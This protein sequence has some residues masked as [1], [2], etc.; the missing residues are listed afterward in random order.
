MKRLKYTLFTILLLIAALQ[1]AGQS[2]VDK[3]CL[4]AERHYRIK[5]EVGST[6]V[7]QLTD[8]AGKIVGTPTG[9]KFTEGSQEGSE[10]V[11]KWTQTGIFKIVVLQTS[12]FGC[13]AQELGMVEVVVQPKA[14]AGKN[15]SICNG[16]PITLTEATAS[17][18]STLMW[19]TSGDG[20]F[21]DP[22]I[23]HPVY[24]PGPNDNFN[25]TVTLTLTAEG[26]GNSGS[27][28]PAVSSITVVS[29]FQITPL[30]NTIP[31]L[32][33]NSTP[34]LLEGISSN[35][36]KGTWTPAK[37]NTATAGSTSYTFTPDP[38]QC[39]NVKVKINVIVNKYVTP[40][41]DNI[42]PLCQYSTTPAAL[43]TSSKDV[44]AITGAWTPAFSTAKAGNTNYTFVPDK[45]DQC[46]L[47][48]TS[49]VTVNPFI[50]T[51][52]DPIGVVCQNSTAPVLPKISTN[53]TAVRGTW[54]PDKIDTKDLGTFEYI[55]TP[56]D[57]QCA[58]GVK[59]KVTVK[60]VIDPSFNKIGPLCLNN[61]APPLPL[62]STNKSPVTGTWTP[63]VVNTTTVGTTRYDFKPD[64]GQCALPTSLSVAV[65]SSAVIP[66]FAQIE[67]IC[68]GSVVNPLPTTSPNGIT[69]IWSP[70]FSNKAT[71]TYEFTPAAGQCASPVKMTV[72]I[73]AN[74][75]ITPKFTAIPPICKGTLV[76]PLPNTSVEGI[77][78]VWS[79]GFNNKVNTTYTFTPETG[80]CALPAQL[81]VT[82][83]PGS[84]IPIFAEIA[85]CK[86]APG[87][88]LPSTSLDGITGTWSPA[89]DNTVTSKYTFTPDEGQCAKAT[90]LTVTVKPIITPTF[91]QMDTLCQHSIGIRA[92]PA[93]STNTTPITG[94]WLPA[95][96]TAIAGKTTYTFTPGAGQCADKGAIDV[97]VIPQIAPLF[98]K[99]DTLCQYSTTLK[100]LPTSSINTIPITGKWFPAFSTAK[101]GKTSYTF[102]PDAGQC[103]T[104]AKVDVVV[105][106]P[107]ITTFTQI[108]PLCQNSVAIKALP[109]SSANK[110]PI[111]GIW[112]PKFSTETAGTTIYNFKPDSG[113]CATNAKMIV[114][115]N[116]R[117]KPAFIQEGAMC[118]HSTLPTPLRTSSF[119]ATP[120]TGRWSPA[121]STATAGIN[122]YTFTPDSGQC[123]TTAKMGLEIIPQIIPT[124]TQ[125]ATTCLNSS[126]LA[127]PPSVSTNSTPITGKWS[128]AFDPA[129][130]GTTRYTFKPND[131][132]CAAD[133]IM[134]ITI[135]P[136]IIPTFAAIHPL[137][138]NSTP[139]ALAST[140]INGITGTWNPATIN[141]SIVGTTK[142]EFIPDADQC[143]A[144]AS[145][146]IT[147]RLGAIIA[148]ATE[149]GSCVNVLLDGSSSIGDISKYEWSVLD[150]GGQLT[151]TLGITTEFLLSPS[152]AGPLPADFRVRLEV[153]DDQGDTSSDTVSIKVD[154]RPVANIYSSGEL[155]KDGGM[156]VDGSVST[157]KALTYKWSTTVGTILSVDDEAT[158]LLN[159]AG[160]Y[161][162]EV[163][164][165]YG[166]K[167]RKNFVF[168]FDL[169]QI[170]ARPD[171]TRTSWAN[172]TII[173]VLANDLSTVKLLTGSVQVV[174]QPARGKTKV[175]A[176]G[177]ITYTPVDRRPGRDEF[178]YE[179]CDALSFC[180]QATV[181]I[182]I[183]DSGIIATE[184]FS[185][186]GDGINDM[187]VFEGLERYPKSSLYIYTRS[188][189]LVYESNNYLNDWD[190][191]TINSTAN[192]QKLVP[193]GTYYY[194]LKLGGTNR[195]MKGFIYVGY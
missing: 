186:N 176:D 32:C 192:S 45:K 67:P 41:F 44:P 9:S 170:I 38:K 16:T 142:Y 181:T 1:V 121:F 104:V 82:V 96:S 95:F 165:S 29:D 77:T 11:V 5:G 110:M 153:S 166:C 155:E 98:A 123:A 140:S 158:A 148:G 164:D 59:I 30:F 150:T 109:S 190:G 154:S 116:G 184:G 40:S 17:D 91:A 139:P 50:T 58:S 63:S 28:T 118:Q 193:S 191:R 99:I 21:N 55:F 136:L 132:Q 27:C 106:S 76:N 103:A 66:D 34:P 57:G 175:N 86:G 126:T 130:V 152:Y 46:Y 52:F 81:L 156:V 15:F 195:S 31:L 75:N 125:I 72:K 23:L 93:S 117:T 172:D 88:P 119:N 168:P 183:Y 53:S 71:G 182:D 100:A 180:A 177:S 141:T 189:Q 94:T 24:T 169:H 10:V 124:F 22:K 188:G 6:Y 173:K 83:D 19:S 107:T 61:T 146:D 36:I 65:N 187:L 178:I 128:P 159:G 194:V 54:S 179:V 12:S 89:F 37:I 145:L 131:G 14:F 56:D 171:Y 8:A 80:Q 111:T 51:T 39:T 113:Q 167:D 48:A 69:G 20:T 85:I 87:N 163:T 97:V 84:I 70:A 147:V 35:S 18:Y 73:N 43:P 114:V 13:K 33:L 160:L 42:V 161:L 135:D 137:Y 105:V 122:N 7:W 47:N 4:G 157:G 112:S 129:K 78:G 143:A 134:D 26:K 79:P 108:D 25:E 144:V 151:R 2:Y 149:T 92:L 115:I 138:Q 127:F 64:D 68:K 102:T 90:T 101:A 60:P 174:S 62:S 3:V 185:P 133:A 74:S 49:S 120:I 162:L